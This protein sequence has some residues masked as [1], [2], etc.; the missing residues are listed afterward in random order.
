MT[1]HNIDSSL[2]LAILGRI[3]MQP[4]S[5][6]E[7]RKVFLTTA[8]KT[9]SSSP[10]A[11]YPA[12]KRLEAGGFIKGN[13][14]KQETLR[15]RKIY[16]LTEKGRTALIAYLSRPITR[17]DIVWRL[18]SIPLRFAFMETFMGRD[19]ILSFLQQLQIEMGAYLRVLIAENKPLKKDMSFCGWAAFQLGMENMKAYIRW[20]K[21]T[22]NELNNIKEDEEICEMEGRHG[23]P[24]LSLPDNEHA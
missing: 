11:I 19:K 1:A 6:Y 5:G 18:D 20:A 24:Q 15:P 2:S 8:W 9:Y 3:S 4:L 22:H 10:G 7:V 13:I 17:E 12:L 14:E 23:N 16:V 21:N